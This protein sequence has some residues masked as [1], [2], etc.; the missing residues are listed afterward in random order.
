MDR[1]FFKGAIAEAKTVR[2]SAIANAKAA[3]EEAF[4]PKMRSMLATKLE[5][6][7]LEEEDATNEVEEENY[8][9][10]GKGE[11]EELDLDEILAELE[12]ELSEE[13][14]EEMLKEEEEVEMETEED[15]MDSEEEV[16]MDSD[17][18]DIDL[19]DMTE[20]ELKKFIEDV[21]EDMVQ[22]GEL[23]AGDSA[24]EE[25]ED[26][27]EDDMDSEEDEVEIEMEDDVE[28][29]E[30]VNEFMGIGKSK[31]VAEEFASANPELI[32]AAKGKDQSS[33][34]F[35]TLVLKFNSYLRKEGISSSYRGN[36]MDKL[37]DMVGVDRKGKLAP[38]ASTMENEDLS[39]AVE[40]INTLRSELNEINLLNSKLL[41]T[42]KI[43]K[44]KNLTESQKVKVLNAFDNANT[45]KEAKLVF[46]TLNNS[47]TKSKTIVKESRMGSASKSISKVNTTTKQPIVE[48]NEMVKRF[49]KL[50]GIK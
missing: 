28:S 6:M 22:A 45:T 38:M 35:K 8:K 9:N 50:A 30:E 15:E 17:D 43:F 2:E 20:D 49:Q 13:N 37:Y 34:E 27:M 1:D 18:E 23:E 33:D 14:S 41:Y 46:E 21:I 42:N 16:E 3:L 24:E 40:T 12:N 29:K 26:E 4:E 5:E 48:S 11:V 19:E 32:D 25:M 39:E 31:K 36:Y 10:E 7:E 44:A 47:L